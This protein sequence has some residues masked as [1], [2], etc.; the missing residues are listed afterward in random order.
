[1][2]GD[3]DPRNLKCN[4][5][6]LE[7]PPKSGRKLEFPEVDRAAWFNARAA[8]RKINKGQRPILQELFHRLR[9][10]SSRRPKSSRT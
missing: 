8:A 7:W 4:T 2:E 9:V 5:F 1:V 6:S 10:K 3:F